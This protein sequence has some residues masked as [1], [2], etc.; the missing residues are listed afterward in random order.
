LLAT[1]RQHMRTAGGPWASSFR[2]AL[3]VNDHIPTEP[4][5]SATLPCFADGGGTP[6]SLRGA[7][8][9]AYLIAASRRSVH[10]VPGSKPT[11]R[12]LFRSK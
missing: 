11:F 3:P 12:K 2:G 5:H 6:R 4:D 9:L 7:S 8:C 1:S 10:R